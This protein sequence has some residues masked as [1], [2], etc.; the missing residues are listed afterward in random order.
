MDN[1]TSKE[2]N[3]IKYTQFPVTRIQSQAN[4]FSHDG[5][6]RSGLYRKLQE[7]GAI[8]RQYM[9]RCGPI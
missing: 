5:T 9:E 4:T 7:E 1:Q 3:R 6:K 8:E 2:K